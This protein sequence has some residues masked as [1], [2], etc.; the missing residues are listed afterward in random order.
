MIVTPNGFC[1]LTRGCYV[2]EGYVY[3][4]F[5]TRLNKDL[6]S[7][8]VLHVNLDW[9]D[10]MRINENFFCFLSSTLSNYT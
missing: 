3:V 7:E 5:L 4:R 10:S 2:D 9:V 8:K 6:Q 1:A